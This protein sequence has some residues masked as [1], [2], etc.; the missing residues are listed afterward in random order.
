[1][2]NVMK[3]KVFQIRPGSP[4]LRGTIPQGVAEALKLQHGDTVEW[5]L[6]VR[7][8]KIVATIEKKETPSLENTR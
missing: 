7:D 2:R 3:S 6:T 5:S 8:G 4:S 1:M